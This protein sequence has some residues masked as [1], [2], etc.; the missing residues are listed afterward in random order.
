MS[1]TLNTAALF[2]QNGVVI[3]SGT[4]RLYLPNQSRCT[5][6]CNGSYLAFHIV[7][8]FAVSVRSVD[9]YFSTPVSLPIVIDAPFVAVQFVSENDSTERSV[10]RCDNGT[11]NL[12]NGSSYDVGS[13]VQVLDGSYQ[14]TNAFLTSSLAAC[15]SQLN[16]QLST[17]ST[18]NQSV[19]ELMQTV[20]ARDT[21]IVELEATITCLRALADDLLI[22]ITL[23]TEEIDKLLELVAQMNALLEVQ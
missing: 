19:V 21:T 14:V 15:Q 11:K 4:V 6:G 7:N 20:D 2:K 3:A 13:M 8:G 1:V 18:C 17:N 22:S 23:K 12:V 5:N 16:S 10:C 9:G